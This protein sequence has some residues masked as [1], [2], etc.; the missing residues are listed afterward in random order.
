FDVLH[1]H[2]PVAPSLSLL[3]IMQARGPIVAT[4]HT[5]TPRSRSLSAAQSL[6]QPFLER[7]SGRIAVSAAA[8]QVQV[9]HLGGDAVEDPNG[10][11]EPHPAAAAPV[12]GDAR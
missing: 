6:L 2:E 12:A 3:A 5:S 11:A 10:V 9:E 7:I 8:R 4:F 1:V